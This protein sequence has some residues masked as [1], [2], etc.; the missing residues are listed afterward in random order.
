VGWLGIVPLVLAAGFR[1]PAARA[2]RMVAATFFLWAL[3]PF[4]IVGGFDTGLKL[5][6]ILLRFLPFVAHARMPCRAMVVVYAALA[7]IV[8]V[9]VAASERRLRGPVVQSLLV[10]LVVFD[11]W[12]APLPLTRLDHPAVYEALAHAEAGAVCEVP[13]GIGDG[14]SAGIGSQERRALFYATQHEHPL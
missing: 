9:R 4:L 14:L 11:F 2:W 6:A 1:S 7:I 3:G 12:D 10:A 13:L 5:P 8:A